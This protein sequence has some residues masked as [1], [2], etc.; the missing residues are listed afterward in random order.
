MPMMSTLATRDRQTTAW[1]RDVNETDHA[2]TR[3]RFAVEKHITEQIVVFDGD[4][5]YLSVQFKCALLKLQWCSRA[6]RA[7]R[8]FPRTCTQY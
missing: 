4:R 3:L 8:F 2:Q 5:Y 7:Q 6:A 1:W